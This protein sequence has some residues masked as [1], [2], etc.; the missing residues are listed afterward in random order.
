MIW[1]SSDWKKPL[2][3]LSKK[4]N[5]WKERSLSDKDLIDIEKRF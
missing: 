1:E 5:K 4:I 3:K 2:L